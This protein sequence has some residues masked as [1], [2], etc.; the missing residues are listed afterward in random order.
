MREERLCSQICIHLLVGCYLWNLNVGF[1]GCLCYFYF[2]RSTT[3][4]LPLRTDWLHSTCPSSSLA[5]LCVMYLIYR[6]LKVF[7]A[8]NSDSAQLLVFLCVPFVIWGINYYCDRSP[9]IAWSLGFLVNC[10]S[11]SLPERSDPDFSFIY[12]WRHRLH[13]ENQCG[14]FYLSKV[15]RIR[16]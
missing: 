16:E 4:T 11:I 15:F 12:K 5:L 9:S 7:S 8:E 10:I 1:T 3:N 6:K 14:L 2:T 13:W